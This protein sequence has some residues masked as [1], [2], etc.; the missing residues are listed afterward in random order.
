MEKAKGRPRLLKAGLARVKAWRQKHSRDTHT[1]TPHLPI[2]EDG[3]K[4]NAL[5]GKWGVFRAE[6][7]RRL[8]RTGYFE[9]GFVYMITKMERRIHMGKKVRS[10]DHTF[11]KLPEGTIGRSRKKGDVLRDCH[12]MKGTR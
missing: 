12:D 4:V 5:A 11:C 7:T 3:W 10:Y 1:V 8:I 9:R 2:G 6:M